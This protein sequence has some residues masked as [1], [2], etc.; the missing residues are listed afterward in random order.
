M[1]WLVERGFGH[2]EE[3]YFA[4][5]QLAQ[6]FIL[7]WVAYFNGEGAEHLRSMRPVMFDGMFGEVLTEVAADYWGA[8]EVS[9]EDFGGGD[10]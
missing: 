10:S 7:L 2:E 5:K 3:V 6:D 8:D 9:P 1:P 4:S